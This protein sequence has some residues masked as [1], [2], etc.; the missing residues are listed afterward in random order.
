MFRVQNNLVK[1]P[2]YSS[3]CDKIRALKYFFN[4]QFIHR[5]VNRN[6]VEIY[7]P[8]SRSIPSELYVIYRYLTVCFRD[9]EISMNKN[10]ETDCKNTQGLRKARVTR[11]RRAHIQRTA[12][13]TRNSNRVMKRTSTIYGTHSEIIICEKPFKKGRKT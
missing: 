6:L 1:F 5:M 4:S 11:R 13:K 2:M 8:S 12:L 9:S 10:N 3:V 7:L